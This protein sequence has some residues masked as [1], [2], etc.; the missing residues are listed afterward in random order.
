MDNIN[1]DKNDDKLFDLYTL[2]ELLYQSH[3]KNDVNAI[4]ELYPTSW[5]ENRNYKLKI[6]IMYE[7]IKTNTLIENTDIYQRMIEDIEYKTKG[8]VI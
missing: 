1:K 2:A 6:E 8:L 4:D 7:A 3:F 5:Y